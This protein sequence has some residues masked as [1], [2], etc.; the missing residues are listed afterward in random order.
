MRFHIDMPLSPALARWL[1]DNGHQGAHATQRGLE[2]AEDETILRLARDE[3]A[4][5]LTADLDYPRLLALSGSDGPG[6]L[7]FRGGIWRE[8]EI[9]ERL[10]HTLAMVSENELPHSIIIVERSRIR[11]RRLPLGQNEDN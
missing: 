5:V 11:R 9:L 2:R 3:G 8:D 7:L 4:I 6:I 1:T 10:E